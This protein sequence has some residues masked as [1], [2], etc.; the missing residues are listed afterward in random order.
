MA[1]KKDSQDICFIPDGDYRRFVQGF[2]GSGQGD[3]TN[4]PGNILNPVGD[5]IGTHDGLTGFTI[6]QRKGFEVKTTE[7]L[8]VLSINAQQNTVTVGPYEHALRKGLNLVLPIYSGWESIPG[9]SRL[10]IRIRSSAKRAWCLATS[11]TSA[12]GCRIHVELEEPV[13][14]PAPGQ[15]GVLYDGETVVAGGFIGR[16]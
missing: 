11:E 3:P 10:Q 4:S 12:S 15:S 7:R 6:G 13:F 5:V 14:A 2:A 9:S 8:Y 16:D 1:E